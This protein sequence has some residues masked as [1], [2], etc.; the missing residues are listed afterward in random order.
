MA[1]FWR[2]GKTGIDPAFI[3]C[4]TLCEYGVMPCGTLCL[5]S[6]NTPADWPRVPG[7]MITMAD[8]TGEQ[9]EL[10]REDAEKFRRLVESP[11]RD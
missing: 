10:D 4:F 2:F 11:D 5:V 3:A 1:K 8:G 6:K 7:V 9:I